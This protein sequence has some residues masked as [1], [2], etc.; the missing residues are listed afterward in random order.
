M[1]KP[2]CSSSEFSQD[3]LKSKLRHNKRLVHGVQVR[4]FSQLAVLGWLGS[5]YIHQ[6]ASKEAARIDALYDAMD[7]NRDGKLLVRY[8]PLSPY[9]SSNINKTHT[10]THNTPQDKSA[11]P[12]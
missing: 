11:R 9:L 2:E 8:Q 7:T 10:H 6:M 12:R 4:Y 5:A 3:S 1:G